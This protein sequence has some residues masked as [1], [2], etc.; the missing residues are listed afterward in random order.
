[1]TDNLS[2]LSTP[3]KIQILFTCCKIPHL[4]AEN[5]DSACNRTQPLHGS[6]EIQGKAIPHRIGT[7]P[8]FIPIG[9]CRK[10]KYPSNTHCSSPYMYH[11]YR[12]QIQIAVKAHHTCISYCLTLQLFQIKIKLWPR[13]PMITITFHGLLI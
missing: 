10:V 2:I 7:S 1:M 13:N 4:I 9:Q 6:W 5:P 3:K 12:R 8:R 11:F